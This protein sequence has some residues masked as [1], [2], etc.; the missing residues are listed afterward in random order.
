MNSN[1]PEK[2]SDD[3]NKTVDRLLIID[4]IR[5]YHFNLDVME[6]RRDSIQI[7]FEAL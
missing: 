7:P 2:S 1:S 4:L 6:S 5:N 3:F